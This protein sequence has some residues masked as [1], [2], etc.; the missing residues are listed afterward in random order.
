MREILAWL[1]LGFG[2]LNLAL[3]ITLHAAVRNWRKSEATFNA[4]RNELHKLRHSFGSL[5]AELLRHRH[6]TAKT[7]ERIQKT[8]GKLGA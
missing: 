1:I 8:Q 2:I 6:V 5:Q 4:L 3:A 7:N